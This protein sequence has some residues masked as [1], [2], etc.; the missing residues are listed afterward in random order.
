MVDA[1]GPVA[2]L[3]GAID[4]MSWLP[5]DSAETDV[6][7]YTSRD[8]WEQREAW[9][10]IEL[11]EDILDAQLLPKLENGKS[12]EQCYIALAD[13]EEPACVLFEL[14]SST[15]EQHYITFSITPDDLY[16]LRVDKYSTSLILGLF[17]PCPSFEFLS[18]LFPKRLR[19]KTD[20][21]IVAEKLAV[22]TCTPAYPRFDTFLLFDLV[23]VE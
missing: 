7:V 19:V 13:N 5:P 1:A 16:L 23:G 12:E 18:P 21:I 11:P 9:W 14:K 22:L 4:H 3:C 2:E 17:T 6:F 20:C 15:A 10:L 8:L